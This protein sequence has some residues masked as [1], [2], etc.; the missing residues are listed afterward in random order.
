[1]RVRKLTT[2]LDDQV[3]MNKALDVMDVRWKQLNSD[4]YYQGITNDSIPLK[5]TTLPGSA[6]FR[7]CT[8][9]LPA[10]YYVWYHHSRRK[11]GATKEDLLILNNIWLLKDNW[12]ESVWNT[13]TTTLSSKQWL[14]SITK[15]PNI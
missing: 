1:L 11:T 7:N 6:I 8:K 3:I 14:L 4:G 12:D 15:V 2:S 13:S 10:N 9:G 5:I